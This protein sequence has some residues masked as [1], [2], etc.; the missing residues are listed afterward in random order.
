M[1]PNGEAVRP[2][3]GGRGWERRFAWR[4]Q[5]ALL[6]VFH[7][8]CGFIV[9]PLPRYRLF[10]RWVLRPSISEGFGLWFG[11]DD[12]EDRTLSLSLGRLV[13]VEAA[14]TQIDVPAAPGP[15]S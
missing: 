2:S 10:V 12:D 15:L 5:S 9:L 7:R 3:D 14:A 8:D 11:R 6:R 13:A 1:T 4:G